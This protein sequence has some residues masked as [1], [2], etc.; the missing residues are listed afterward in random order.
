MIR[1]HKN[2]E[3]AK[4]QE[5]FLADKDWYVY[6][7]NYGTLEEKAFVKMFARRYEFFQERLQRY[8]LDPKRKSS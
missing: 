5:G 7:A 2:D 1:I 3:R 6:N 4:G 8:I